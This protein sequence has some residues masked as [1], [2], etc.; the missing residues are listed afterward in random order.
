M[1]NKTTKPT[2]FDSLDSISRMREIE[3][4]LRKITKVKHPCM[5]VVADATEKTLETAIVFIKAGTPAHDAV[6]VAASIAG[7]RNAHER[8]CIELPDDFDARDH[9]ICWDQPYVF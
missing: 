6:S 7:I 9:G 3:S 2:G 8:S 5:I 4:D 1:K